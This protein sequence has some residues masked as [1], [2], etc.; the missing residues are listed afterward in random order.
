MLPK[1]KMSSK[2]EVILRRI[3]AFQYNLPL[4]VHT[5]IISKRNIKLENL[6]A[7]GKYW[8]LANKL[9]SA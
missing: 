4:P 1:F 6:F 8:Q 5:S 3:L 7:K 2:Q 9:E